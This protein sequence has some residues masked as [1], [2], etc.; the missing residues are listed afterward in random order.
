MHS[1]SRHGSREAII[2]Q[3]FCRKA[4][5]DYGALVFVELYAVFQQ[6]QTYV[7]V[8]FALMVLCMAKLF[9]HINSNNMLSLSLLLKIMISQPDITG[10][11]GH[12]RYKVRTFSSALETLILK[13]FIGMKLIV[14]ASH[15]LSFG[16]AWFSFLFS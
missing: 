9:D 15:F 11:L 7:R 1:P 3:M 5:R 14:Y 13:M 10:P 2:F 4:D 6:H 16:I 12:L 8:S